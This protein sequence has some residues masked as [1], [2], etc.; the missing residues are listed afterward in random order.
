[1]RKG[2]LKNYLILNIFVLIVSIVFC[3]EIAIHVYENEVENKLKN[4]AYFIH[5]AILSHH[6]VDKI[7]F[8]TYAKE[9]SQVQ[10]ILDS[11]SKSL[12]LSLLRLTFIDFSGKVLGDSKEDYYAMEN[13]GLKTEIQQALKNQVGKDIRKSKTL[14]E[15]LLYIALPL[16]NINT[17]L[18]VSI[19]LVE[20]KKIWLYGF[21]FILLGGL[22]SAYLFFKISKSF[23]RPL[24]KMHSNIN[25][26]TSGNYSNQIDLN[27]MDELFPLTS[28]FN[29]MT[30]YLKR[31]I[32][33]LENK[34]DELES[35]LTSMTHAILAI[36]KDKNIIF[37]NL[38]AS[39]LFNIEDSTMV[40]GQ[41]MLHSVRN[42][43][44]HQLL[45]TTI[46]KNAHQELEML[47]K[48]DIIL[49]IDTSPIV[50]KDTVNTG[51]I[52]YIQ[53]I[54]RIRKLEQ[55]RTEFVS[56]VT[57][58]LKTP[59]TSIKGFIDT[60]KNGSIHDPKRAM[61]F[62]DIIDIESER[63]SSLI[64]DILDLSEIEFK[65]TDTNIINVDLKELTDEVFEL[66]Y[67]IAKEKNLYLV[68]SIE[69]N[70][71]ILANRDR[72]KQLLL[73]L[74]NNGI[75][76]NFK[77]GTVRVHAY[78]APGKIVIQVTDTGI[79]LDEAHISRIFERFYRVDKGRAR[80]VGGTGLG[81]SIVKHI[82]QLY[83]G[84]IQLKSQVNKG[85]EFIIQ[86]PQI[87]S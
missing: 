50:N 87:D 1:M 51:C 79:G 9:L 37:I 54:S 39:K 11:Q 45:I 44:I 40:I 46:E 72:M 30:H 17:I 80:D 71:F 60:L 35:I 76:Y 38:L 32:S 23:Y 43:A 66:S 3:C 12:D 74:V 82:V 75:K 84:D 69:N 77:N 42:H 68:N 86:L 61:R 83:N 47:F 49:R 65:K 26:I 58:E 10:N 36:D 7:N 8:D 41:N 55:L 2:S 24:E 56:N 19:P 29:L 63:L 70:V 14:S 33:N 78:K 4:I 18:R 21:L 48:E 64:S 22:S 67:G 34:K 85:S 13:Q 62:L 25:E 53:D 27:H 28:S 6:E 31:Y 57:H 52:A 73:N 20:K 16:K 59:L 5:Y 15:D 81:L